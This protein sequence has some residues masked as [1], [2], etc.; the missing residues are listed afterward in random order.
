MRILVAICCLFSL[1]V[2]AQPN[3]GVTRKEAVPC[4]Q[5]AADRSKSKYTEWDCGKIAGVVDC[6]QKLEMSQDGKRVVTS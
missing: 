2:S 1:A 4:Y 5:K 3:F 6:N